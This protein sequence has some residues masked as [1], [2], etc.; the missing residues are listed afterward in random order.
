MSKR[1]LA[2]LAAMLLYAAPSLATQAKVLAVYD[3]RS[4]AGAALEATRKPIY[5]VDARRILNAMDKLGISY[6]LVPA[7]VAKTEYCRTGNMVWNPGTAGAYVEHFDAV[8]HLL[9]QS[10]SGSS[11]AASYRMDSTLA[12]RGANNNKTPIVPQLFIGSNFDANLGS[13]WSSATTCSLGTVSGFTINSPTRNEDG[14][15][16]T[17]A[18]MPTSDPAHV[19]LSHSY[20]MGMPLNASTNGGVR[21]L[22]SGSW[23]PE[24]GTNPPVSGINCANCDSIRRHAADDSAKVWSRLF[25]GMNPTDGTA[26]EAIFCWWQGGAPCTDSTGNVQDVPCEGEYPVLLAG[27]ARLDSVLSG[28]LITKY[29]KASVVIAGVASRGERRFSGGS[30][31]SD[32]TVRKASIDSL[33]TIPGFKAVATVE[34]DSASTYPNELTQW[35]AV[36]G[37]RF[38]PVTRYGWSVVP[39]YASS[40]RAVDPFGHLRSR[41][42]VGP[43]TSGDTSYYAQHYRMR[44]ALRLLVG[45]SRLS[46]LCV[47]PYGEWSPLNGSTTSFARDSALYALSLAGYGALL[48]NSQ[49]PDA[50]TYIGGSVNPKG[51]TPPLGDRNALGRHIRLVGHSGYDISGSLIADVRND[52]TP[53]YTELGGGYG[54]PDHVSMAL[55]RFWGPLF[56]PH[57][58]DADYSAWY[59]TTTKLDTD[60]P[61]MDVN[62]PMSDRVVGLPQATVLR[63]SAQQFGGVPNGPPGRPGWWVVKSMDNAM[64]MVNGLAGRVIM[65][66]AYPEETGW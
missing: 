34:M 53:P 6:T 43:G 56:N 33:K 37:L 10:N 1:L 19:V 55:Q 5:S 27:F 64:R 20:V 28:R 57:Y 46:G 41:V 12:I 65:D 26:A 45:D 49:T 13:K 23:L 8:V 16:V 51:W 35:A 18:Y 7:S 2:A 42:F 62:Q 25:T 66:W 39:T 21:S 61:W 63:L 32:S 3:N 36:S 17:A 14:R 29:Q 11:G 52:S 9:W 31:P 44:N 47:A 38:T 54:F 4:T 50:D 60:A 15:Q 40:T 58:Q 22:V 48:V 24:I 59:E 30:T